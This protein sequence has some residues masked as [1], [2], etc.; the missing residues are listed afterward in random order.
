MRG[1]GEREMANSLRRP[2][3]HILTEEEISFVCQEAK[4]IGIPV[5]ALVFND[6][7]MTGF[8]DDEK[9]SRQY[10]SG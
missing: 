3:Q 4:A 10:F 7:A 6:G 9:Y 2:I 8:Y 1:F 5:E